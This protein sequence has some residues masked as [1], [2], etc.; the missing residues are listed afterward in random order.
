MKSRV[1]IPRAHINK[2][3]MDEVAHLKFQPLQVEDPKVS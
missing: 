3:L 2:Y 1:Q